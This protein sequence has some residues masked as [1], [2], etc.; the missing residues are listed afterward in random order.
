MFE[1]PFQRA[2]DDYVGG[3]VDERAFLKRSEY[4]KRWN[5]DYHL[6]KPI[7][8][9]A[10]D[11]RLP[12]VALNARRE[13]VDKVAKSGLDA[14]SKAERNEIPANL[15]F[16]DQEY[17]ARLKEIFAEHKGSGEKNLEFFYQ[18]QILWDETMAESIDQFLKKNPDY[19]MIVLAGS[20]H[21]QYASGIPKRS[22]RRNGFSYGVV[23]NDA[24]IKPRIAD[25]IVFPEA[26]AVPST[27]KI[28]VVVEEQ[29]Q[30]L[31]VK[32]FAKESLAEKAGFKAGDIL[33]SIDGERLSS[34][35]DLQIALFYKKAGET[36]T[37][38]GRRAEQELEFRIKL[39]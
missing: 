34:S 1:R 38:R 31:R 19:R 16:S 3:A 14:L 6:Y 20:G 22:F 29:N 2:V 21:L 5:I 27:P 18:A 23:L 35:D 17:R 8:D 33:E 28:G 7:L 25:F 24:E 15:D 26:V 10:R 37:I 13:I 9:Y 36:V 32:G 11:K 4:F 39:P 30:Q 12:V